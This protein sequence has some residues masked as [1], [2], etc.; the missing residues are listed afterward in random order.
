MPHHSVL[1]LAKKGNS[2]AVGSGNSRLVGVGLEMLVYVT[3][4]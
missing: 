3:V 4:E 1:L 2:C